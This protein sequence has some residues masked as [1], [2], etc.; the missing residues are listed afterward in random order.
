MP[1]PACTR[2]QCKHDRSRQGVSAYQEEAYMD[3]YEEGFCSQ[4]SPS[5]TADAGGR[6][7]SGSNSALCFTLDGPDTLEGSG[8]FDRLYDF[9]LCYVLTRGQEV[10]A[11]NMTRSA[12][13]MSEESHRLKFEE[14]TRNEIDRLDM[15]AAGLMRAEV[16]AKAGH[17]QIYLEALTSSRAIGRALDQLKAWHLYQERGICLE[18]R[19]DVTEPKR[20]TRGSS[21]ARSRRG[22]KS[23]DE[24]SKLNIRYNARLAHTRFHKRNNPLCRKAHELATLS[25]AQ[26]YLV[27]QARGQFS[28][29]TSHE[30]QGW[31]P[32][33]DQIDQSYPLPKKRTATIIRNTAGFWG[34]AAPKKKPVRSPRTAVVLLNHDGINVDDYTRL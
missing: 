15:N 20:V 1:P 6:N 32:S 27:V 11:S 8:S 28:T 3:I 22:C 17:C 10:L 33:Q 4:S 19:V 12:S 23:I 18:L 16:R 21:T 9:E 13:S 25:K 30:H 26:V 2:Q 34:W 24:E 5:D 31:P 29:Y 7:D 14:W